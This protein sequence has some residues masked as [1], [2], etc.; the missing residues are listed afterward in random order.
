MS[1]MDQILKNARKEAE[2]VAQDQRRIQK[3]AEAAATGKSGKDQAPMQ[4]GQREYP[5]KFPPE[6]QKKP[7]SET[8]LDPAP[9]YEAPDYR[10]S[11]KLSGKAALITGGD[12]GIGR[13]VA[14]LYARE[15]AD[16]AIVYLSEHEDAE[17]TKR[18]VE[19]EGRRC[20]LISGDVANSAFCKAAVD[21]TVET[22]GRLD[23]L[24]N[25]A[26]FQEHIDDIVNLTRG[27]ARKAK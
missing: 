10:G 8:S 14:V 4:A 9:M 12:S 13:A 27:A 22:F 19:A 3:E 18:L 24:V 23:V 6:A 25:N 7:G 21:K 15:G 17:E 5:S 20:I 2:A 26:A 1:D 16:I 11:E